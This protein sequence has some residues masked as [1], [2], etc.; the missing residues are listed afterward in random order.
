M[1]AHERTRQFRAAPFAP[2]DVDPRRTHQP[3]CRLCG[4]DIVYVEMADTGKLYP[5]DPGT[6]AGDGRRQLVVR[7]QRGRKVVG[8]VVPRAPDTVIGLRPHWA[9]CPCRKRSVSRP[10]APVQASLFD[11]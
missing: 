7:G 2:P 5:C 9:T 10:D 8:K 6:V 1:R 11:L 4:R 3:T